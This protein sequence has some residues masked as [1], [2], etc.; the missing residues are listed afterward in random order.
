MRDNDDS[1]KVRIEGAR[2]IGAIAG[3]NFFVLDIFG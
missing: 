2:M 1:E 3:D